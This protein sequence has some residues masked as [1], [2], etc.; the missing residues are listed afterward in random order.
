MPACGRPNLGRRRLSAI[1][2]HCAFVKATG[3]LFL[4]PSAPLVPKLEI[5][6]FC[7]NAGHSDTR[8]K[9]LSYKWSMV[10]DWDDIL[11]EIESLK[12]DMRRIVDAMTV[13]TS[14]LDQ[15]WEALR[16]A[17]SDFGNLNKKV[18]TLRALSPYTKKYGRTG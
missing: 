11:S 10:D 5:P 13:T 9:R 16:K 8:G 14:D 15:T 7:R 2:R 17:Q 12:Q 4:A 18:A 1:G 3:C 6:L